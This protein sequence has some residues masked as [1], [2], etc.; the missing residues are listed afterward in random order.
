MRANDLLDL[1]YT[2]V[3]ELFG[4][5]DSRLLAH[6]EGGIRLVKC[7]KLVVSCNTVKTSEVRRALR[8]IRVRTSRE[9]ERECR[10][11]PGGGSGCAC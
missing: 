7:E 1:A 5:A 9:A 10:L 2:L 4:V 11:Q 6:G 8:E 3:C